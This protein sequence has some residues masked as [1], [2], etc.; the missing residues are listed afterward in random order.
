MGCRRPPRWSIQLDA[1]GGLANTPLV[2]EA[3]VNQSGDGMLNY[4]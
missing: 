4:M 1:Q 3:A 2:S